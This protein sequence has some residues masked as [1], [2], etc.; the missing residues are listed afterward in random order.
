MRRR[1]DISGSRMYDF[2]N[3]QTQCHG[4]AAV[5][6]H[7]LEL[8]GVTRRCCHQDT[9]ARTHPVTHPHQTMPL[10][11]AHFNRFAGPDH[12]RRIHPDRRTIC[13]SPA[14]RIARAAVGSKRPYRRIQPVR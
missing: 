14:R 9:P 11:D 10:I 1:T 7:N 3:C 5:V 4:L 8:N 2:R 12:E 13:G 6:G